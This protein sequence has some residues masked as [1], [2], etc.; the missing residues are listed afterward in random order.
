MAIS[1]ISL[2]FIAG[3]MSPRYLPQTLFIGSRNNF[4]ERLP[5]WLYDDPIPRWIWMWANLDGGHYVSIAR[6]GYYEGEYGFFP[7]YPIII[8]IIHH[9]TTVPFVLSGLL[10]SGVALI[11]FFRFSLLLTRKIAPGL[12]LRMLFFWFITSPAAFFLISVYNDSLYLLL[13][14]CS[15]YA[16]EKKRWIH[17]C[18]ALYLAGLTRI[19][20]LALCTAFIAEGWRLKK[21]RLHLWKAALFSPLGTLT[22]LGYLHLFKG[23]WQ[24]FFDSMAVWGQD[25]FTFPIQTLWRYV[26]ILVT[27]QQSDYTYFITG[28]EFFLMIFSI[29]LLLIGRKMIR[30]SLWVY[31]LTVVLLPSTSGT[32]AG[33]PRYFIHAFPLFLIM[34]IIFR[35]NRLMAIATGLT[36]LTI[37]LLFFSFF[38][39][40]YFVS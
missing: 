18:L 5:R 31:A 21:D 14:I 11:G 15:F 27:Y 2:L 29:I 8:R 9:L 3:Y 10:I 25:K 34:D 28:I 20:G 39:Q 32:G 36:F 40:G 7:L 19:T 38:S 33:F 35:K 26:K 22:Y 13:A 37:Q 12:S 24:A 23:G 16:I 6:D 30:L 17:A 1:W 4:N